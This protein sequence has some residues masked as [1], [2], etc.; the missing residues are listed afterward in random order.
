MPTG[1]IALDARIRVAPA[2]SGAS[3]LA[4]APYP[5]EL[6]GTARLR[7][8]TEID[9]R[10]IRPEDEPLLHDLV[11]H[12][13]PEDLRLRFL[14]PIRAL[15]HQLAARLTQIDY[16]REMAL[17]AAASRHRARHRA[18]SSP[19]LTACRPNTRSRCAATG[20]VA[21]SAMC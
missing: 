9:L 3:R 12:M 11:A 14:A 1:V 6:A 5:R 7:D 4:I 18:L 19:I 10:P 21:V 13:T 16:D 20:R 15:S 17:V 2:P 8:G